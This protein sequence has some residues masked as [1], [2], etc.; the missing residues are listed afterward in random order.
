MDV[1]GSGATTPRRATPADAAALLALWRA[2]EATPSPTD[3]PAALRRLLAEPAAVLGVVVAPGH[4]PHDRGRGGGCWPT[5]R[6]RCWESWWRRRPVRIFGECATFAGQRKSRF[7]RRSCAI[8][9]A[10]ELSQ[11][12]AR[13]PDV[14]IRSIDAERRADDHA[15]DFAVVGEVKGH[16]VRFLVEA[17]AGGYPRDVR[18]AIWRLAEAR[19]LEQP[20]ADVPLVAAPAI[21][22]SSRALLRRHKMAYWDAGGS[23]YLELPWALY[24]IERA[25]PPGR[26]RVVRGV[27]RG[28]AAQVLHALLLEPGKAWHVGELA[29]RAHV[30]LSTVHQVCTSLEQQLWVEKEGRGP[31]AVRVLREPGALLDAWAAAHS[32]ATYEARRFHRWAREPAEILRAAANALAGAGIAHALTLGSGARLVAPYGT[33]AERAWVLV[34]ASA[35]GTLEGIA[36]AS[37]LQP[38]EDGEAVTFLLTGERSPL[39]FR[40]QVQGFWVASDVQ[41]Y[42]DLWAWPQRGKEQARHL[43]AERLGY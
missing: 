1:G 25:V 36:R 30:S 4:G 33:D 39:M 31:R 2:A 11:A 8:D 17:R 23:L 3:D 32:L 21:S 38:V 6:R 13:L 42:L 27:Y 14:E 22:E 34:P 12:L 16:P 24:L 5:R 28:S 20:V 29:E 18:Q 19:R 9:L 40:R 10:H 41:L 35:A 15:Y 26:P 37:E 7:P 43:R